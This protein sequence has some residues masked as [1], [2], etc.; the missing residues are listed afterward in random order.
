[1]TSELAQ[2]ICVF[3]SA[4]PEETRS[5][6]A[7]LLARDLA[8]NEIRSPKCSSRL[9][10]LAEVLGSK[11]G[12]L[13]SV[14]EYDEFRRRSISNWPSGSQITRE[15]GSWVRAVRSA[16]SL[17][18][19][20]TRRRPN[21][22]PSHPYTR[23]EILTSIEMFYSEVGYWPV[24]RAEYSAWATLSRSVQMRWGKPRPRIANLNVIQKRFDSLGCAVDAA[25]ARRAVAQQLG[26]DAD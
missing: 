22:Y 14:R 18:G 1:M 13:P 17:H 12:E 20:I 6:L 21:R 23:D 7:E 2:G 16:A 24:V 19:P 3:A 25:K 8:E 26:L 4:L 5:T 10:L 11:G 15:Y 9:G